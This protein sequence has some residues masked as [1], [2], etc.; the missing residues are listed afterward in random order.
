MEEH[1][2]NRT[3]VSGKDVIRF[4]LHYWKPNKALGLTAA[5]LMFVSVLA[6]AVV[7]VFTGG[8]VDSL[9][10]HAHDDAAAWNGAWRSFA[11]YGALI[12]F[13]QISRITSVLFWNK[14]AV[15]NLKAIVEDSMHKVQRFSSDWHANT[16]AGGTVRKITRGMWSFDVFEDTLLM[17]ILPAIT[18]ML[19]VTVMLSFTL[20]IVGLAASAIIFLYCA[21]SVWMSVRLL[22]PR[23]KISAEADTKMGATLADVITGNPTV[24]TFGAEEREDALFKGVALDWFNK[25]RRAWQ[26]GVLADGVRSVLRI[27]MTL[28]MMAI[29]IWLWRE[30]KASAGDITL[31]LTTFFII[32]GYLRDVGQHIA[33]LQRAIS[34]MEDNIGF[35]LREDDV[36]DIQK[37]KTHIVSEKKRNDMI[38]FDNVGFQYPNGDK[39]IYR[40][41][42]V[43]IRAGEK[44][45]LVGFSGSGKTTFV[46]L[47]QRLYNVSEGRILIDGQDIAEVTLESLRR[48]VALVPQ[49]PIL[50]HRSLKVNI[51]YGKPDATMED[52][53]EAAKKAYAHDFIMSLPHG[54]DTLVGERGVKLSGGERQRVAIARAILADTPILILDE[55]TSS[56]DSISEH[57]IQKA[58]DALMENRTTIT[59]AHRMSTI[60]KADRILVFN[61]GRIEEQGD[62]AS[63]MACADSRYKAL[64]DMQALGEDIDEEIAENIAEDDEDHHERMAAE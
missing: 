55:A 22:A 4:A 27:F 23:F 44:L 8:I 29:T 51:A 13:H 15:K 16:F 49:D 46:K 32:N 53:I 2:K 10:K 42:T 31:V 50:F 9:T 3:P 63:L 17:G 6:D 62:H 28:S 1:E 45:A 30:G 41:L 61:Q 20:P 11:G 36:V 58:L 24:K 21:I 14:F 47:I 19:G 12:A 35:W 52:I 40:N 54:Y 57:Y 64:Y 38:R 56:L 26:T 43:D 59:I 39:W 18:I 34:D 5:G 60:Q 25:S 33:H 7:P 37:A 48:N